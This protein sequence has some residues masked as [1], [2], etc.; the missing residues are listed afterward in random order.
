VLGTIVPV[1][2][3]ARLAH[4]AGATVLI[5]G[6]QAIQ[7][8]TVDVQDLDCDFYAFSGHKLYGPSGIGALYGKEALL[9]AMPPYQGGGEMISSVTLEKSEWA[10]LPHKFEAGTPAIA[11]A[12]GLGAAID[13]VKSIGVERIGAHER[14]L[15]TYATQ[16][17]AAVDGLRLVGTAAG[18]VSVLSFVMDCAHPHDIA[19]IVDRQGVA[20][21]AG[22]HCAQPLMDHLDLSSTARASVA[23]YNT[24]AEIDALA[25]SLDKVRAIFG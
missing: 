20:V 8:M 23:L 15:I 16:R 22:H 9:D 24:R 7:H 10:D 13:Y 21:R 4:D 17:L 19:T 18:K 6:C 5:D 3:V 1:K 12:I 11:Q 2:E 25:D 14:D